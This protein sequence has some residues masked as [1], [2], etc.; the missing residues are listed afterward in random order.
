VTR[1][2][3]F[4]VGMDTSVNLKV[5]PQFNICVIAASWSHNRCDILIVKEN[6]V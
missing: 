6:Y 5:C 4:V 2:L 3:F 1:I